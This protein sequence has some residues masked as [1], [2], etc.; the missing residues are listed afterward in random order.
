MKSVRNDFFLTK[1]CATILCCLSCAPPIRRIS[2]DLSSEKAVSIVIGFTTTAQKKSIKEIIG[3]KYSFNYSYDKAIKAYSHSKDLTVEGQRAL[4]ESYHK[5]DSNVAAEKVYFAMI[6]AGKRI[7]AEDYYNYAMVLKMNGNY[8]ESAKWMDKFA[9]LK[10]AD[11]RV[12][13]Y[14]ANASKLADLQN[15]VPEFNIE[16]QTINST[17][18][19][20]GTAYYKNKIVLIKKAGSH[21][22]YDKW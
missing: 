11:L 22:K 17:A 8:Q 6:S 18:L 4:A 1:S 9:V 10:P 21:K 13:D 3:G 12:K 5:V 20:F 19:D 2:E 7:V 14:L 15:G 16:H